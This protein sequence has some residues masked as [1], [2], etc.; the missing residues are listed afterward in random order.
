MSG[1]TAGI[2]AST[3]CCNPAS[4]FC[5]PC[6]CDSKDSLCGRVLPYVRMIP[7]V[8]ALATCIIGI[9]LV[10]IYKANP[11]LTIPFVAGAAA[12]GYL[13]YVVSQFEAFKS[14]E[15]HVEINNGQIKDRD[16]QLVTSSMHLELSAAQIKE[17]DRQL[18][19]GR[20]HTEELQKALTATKTDLAE[21]V[22]ANG[23]TSETLG[24]QVAELK[25][26]NESERA[27][28]AAEIAEKEA[29]MAKIAALQ[30]DLGAKQTA[31]Q[32]AADACTTALSGGQIA[33]ENLVPMLKQLGGVLPGLSDVASNIDQAAVGFHHKLEEH[34]RGLKK[35]KEELEKDIE[36][37]RAAKA[38]A[39]AAVAAAKAAA[40]ANARIAAMAEQ[41]TREAVDAAIANH[42]SAASLR[43]A[44][45]EA[46]ALFH[47]AI[48]GVP[49]PAPGVV[50]PPAGS[51]LAVGALPV[52]QVVSAAATTG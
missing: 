24:Q 2:P 52:A 10:L 46:R 19:E 17:R 33:I 41:K 50:C 34:V 49:M 27:S 29:A 4:L 43:G 8:M 14:L 40:E 45:G 1:P 35:L 47:A 38:E 18:A 3:G 26:L 12:C 9:A 15:E 42:A 48:G 36:K 25:Q 44:A 16:R 21:Q 6:G 7:P 5:S 32:T 30:T 28:K 20:T 51:V 11:Y 39:D 37:A 23:R 22:A 13:I 31:L